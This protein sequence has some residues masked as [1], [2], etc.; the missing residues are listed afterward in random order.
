MK[1]KLGLQHRR[2]MTFQNSAET[3]SVQS[4]TVDYLDGVSAPSG[5]NTDDD[6]AGDGGSSLRYSTGIH[7]ESAEVDCCHSGGTAL[8][9]QSS[10]VSLPPV[11][12]CAVSLTPRNSAVERQL[13][14]DFQY[15]NALIGQ[16]S[17]A[18]ADVKTKL[19]QRLG[20]VEDDAQMVNRLTHQLV[21][22]QV[23]ANLLVDRLGPA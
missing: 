18:L 16:L 21:E 15:I 12:L 8:A 14:S 19:G 4:M 9:I 10:S 1:L 22:V 20:A 3:D 2:A 17:G 11:H 23:V 13:L 7:T 6:G 5:T